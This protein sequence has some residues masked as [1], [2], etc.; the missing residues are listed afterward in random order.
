METNRDWLTISEAAGK[1]GVTRQRMH[2]IIGEL[3]A[4]TTEIHPRMHVISK[5][6]LAKIERKRKVEKT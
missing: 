1:L 2:Q 3:Q 4:K 6:E 5:Q